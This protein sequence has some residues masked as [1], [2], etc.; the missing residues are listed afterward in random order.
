MSQ[1]S[2]INDDELDLVEVLAVLWSHK[3]LVF[4]LTTIS[5]FMGGYYA[6]TTDKEFTAAA[7]FKIENETNSNFNLSSE[8]GALATL[9]G[10][11]NLGNNDPSNLLER[12]SGREF[13]LDVTKNTD[14]F[15]DPFFNTYNPNYIDPIWKQIIKNLIGWQASAAEKNTIIENKLISNY[16]NFVQI[17]RTK[18]GAFSISVTHEN[19][20]LAA[21]YAN[22]IMHE[23]RQLVEFES[24]EAQDFRLS[25]LSETLADALQD[26]E[27]AQK[28]LKD[29]ALQNSSSARENFIMGSIQL[30]EIR[31]ERRRVEEISDVLSVIHDLIKVGNLN[32]STYETLR[33]TYPLIDDVDFRRILGMSETISAWSWPSFET[34]EAVSATLR[35]RIKRLDVEVNKMQENAKIYATSA[36]ELAKFTRDAKI[37]EATYT[38]LIE[39]VKSQSL[40]AGFRPE[41]FQVFEYATTP[42]GPSS[43]KRTFILVVSAILGI[44][45]SSAIVLLNS[46]RR[47]IFYTKSAITRSSAASLILHSRSLKKFSSWPITKITS[48][49]SKHR[50]LEADEAEINL[51][52]KKLI[53]IFNIGG[54]PTASDVARLLATK[55]SMSGRKVVLCDKT[56]N[57]EKDTE[58]E[59]TEDVSGVS[60]ARLNNKISV[61]KDDKEPS[62]FTSTKFKTRIETLMA[63]YDQIFICASNKESFLGLMALKDLNPSIVLLA[64]LKKTRRNDVKKIKAN[65][66]ID[67]LFYD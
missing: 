47:G 26:M 39:Q 46:A 5:V 59:E 65:Q 1:H 66:P 44:F 24:K 10:L 30:D 35:D 38:V 58:D 23:I 42:I 40:A 49:I 61:L 31:M 27:I 43:P 41:K 21:R 18:G 12:F 8:F 15:S 52:Q 48:Y 56:G 55:S 37:A 4:F 62:F 67:V 60:I 29:Y 19:P 3:L 28:N 45:S 57:S 34:V 36:E 22:G 7:I 64:R 2:Y 54:R 16:H 6:L 63:S 9:A 13:I 17:D 20:K 32:K 33:S 14:I 50:V 25:Y 11:N 53:Y 51:S